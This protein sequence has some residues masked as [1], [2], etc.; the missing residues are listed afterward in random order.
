MKIGLIRHFK[1]NLEHPNQRLVGVQEL[2][3]WFRDY[4]QADIEIG[5]I[6]LGN[7][8]WK[9]CYS[10]DLKRAFKTAS[11]I[12]QGEIIKTEK[13]REIPLPK[14]KRNMS[15]PFIVWVILIRTMWEIHPSTKNEIENAK[16]KV[17]KLLDEII[18]KDENT[19]IVSH[20]AVMVYMGKYL[21][22]QGFMGP[23]LIHP[24][25]GILY[26]FERQ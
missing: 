12:Y 9:K 21:E 4:D 26:L 24:Q 2:N 16:E 7:H 17:S 11:L 3:K 22:K 6:D 19:L 23:K 1:V 5:K 10:S 13:L 20:A 14:L 25:N 15:L 8:H 18:A